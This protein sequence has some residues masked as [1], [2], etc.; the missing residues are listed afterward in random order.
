MTRFQIFTRKTDLTHEQM[1]FRRHYEL[2]RATTPT[3][4]SLLR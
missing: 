2:M 4:S 3:N 1:Q